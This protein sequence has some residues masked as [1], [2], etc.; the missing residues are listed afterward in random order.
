MNSV[1]MRV[2]G[3]EKAV[4]SLRLFPRKLQTKQVRIAMN[5]A[6]APIKRD[7]IANAPSDTGL[8]KKSLRIKVKV[9]D[10][11]YNVK[12]HGKPAYGLVGA[13]RGIFGVRS[14]GKKGLGS[15]LAKTR[16][17]AVKLIKGG[18]GRLQTVRE[19]D[20]FVPLGGGELKTHARRASRYSHFAEKGRKG[21]GGTKFLEKATASASPRA[22]EEFV[23]KLVPGI[24]QEA[25]NIYAG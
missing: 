11:S 17:A 13:G 1:F 2:E 24:Y 21:K 5:A 16:A 6:M 14:I 4:L 18:K 10:A 7:A 19:R 8:L 9:P 23:R 20:R 22:R 12:H 15:V 25:A 3:A